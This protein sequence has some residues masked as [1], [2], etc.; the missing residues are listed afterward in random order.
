MS[1][2]SKKHP[3]MVLV[4]AA[5]F[6][7]VL[8]L[9]HCCLVYGEALSDQDNDAQIGID[10]K[11]ARSSFVADSGAGIVSVYETPIEDIHPYGKRQELLLKRR[12]RANFQR[13]IELTDKYQ[14]IDHKTYR[15]L[16]NLKLTVP[17]LRHDGMLRLTMPYTDT[18]KGQ[19]TQGMGDVELRAVYSLLSKGKWAVSSGLEATFD[20][21]EK[22]NLGLGYNTLAPIAAV[23]YSLSKQWRIEPTVK[24]KAALGSDYDRY[25]QTIVDLYLNWKS[26]HNKYWAQIDPKIEVDHV[27]HKTYLSY[28]VEVGRQLGRGVGIYL[29]PAFPLG[30]FSNVEN[31]AID[32]KFN[33]SMECGIKYVF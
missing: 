5:S 14:A 1:I 13:K 25:H 27:K 29:R 3:Y 15:N 32:K 7:A 19:G 17:T 30:K 4:L 26:L 23:S 22:D 10:E 18:N 8:F 2:P 33:W 24:F 6:F 31:D 11:N 9:G 28:E 16:T 12:S 21:S 20:T